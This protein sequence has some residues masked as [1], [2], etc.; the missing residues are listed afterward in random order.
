M[1]V[2][3]CWGTGSYFHPGWWGGCHPGRVQRERGLGPVCT[4]SHFSV[5][6]KIFFR[7]GRRGEMKRENTSGVWDK[8][9][10]CLCPFQVTAV[11]GV[12]QEGTIARASSSGQALGSCGGGGS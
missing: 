1:L 7:L 11:A 5:D 4:K 12:W 2:S 9:S 6:V 10:F 3:S 8:L